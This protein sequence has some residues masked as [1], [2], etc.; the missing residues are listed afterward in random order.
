MIRSSLASRFRAVYPKSAKAVTNSG[1][2]P[3]SPPRYFQ[4]SLGLIIGAGAPTAGFTY[5]F[6]ARPKEIHTT[7]SNG[8]P[9][10]MRDS[11]SKSFV[12]NLKLGPYATGDEVTSA[13]LL[14]SKEECEKMLKLEEETKSFKLDGIRVKVDVNSVGANRVNEDRWAVDVVDTNAMEEIGLERTDRMDT[15]FWGHWTGLRTSLFGEGWKGD[16]EAKE[17][18]L[19]MFSVFDGHGPGDGW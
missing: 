17:G 13:D 12:T 6:T 4:A 8:W 9:C 7:M 3:R 19:V 1:H 15:G 10:T 14:L 2:A 5:Y 18:G 16:D 11:T